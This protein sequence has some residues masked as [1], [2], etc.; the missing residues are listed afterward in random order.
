MLHEFAVKEFL[1]AASSTTSE[2]QGQGNSQSFTINLGG[3]ASLQIQTFRSLD[4]AINTFSPSQPQPPYLAAYH[5]ADLKSGKYLSQ[6]VDA[7]ISFINTIPSSLL[8]GSAAPT[9]RAIDLRYRYTPYMFTR[10]RPAF[11][12]TSKSERK[13]KAALTSSDSKSADELLKEARTP[14]KVMKRSQGGGVG[15]FEQGFLMNAA[16]ILLTGLTVSGLGVWKL[17]QFR[18]QRL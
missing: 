5:F 1:A 11:V 15:F 14:L 6:Y 13:L 2:K 10:S 16:F 9:A 18:S 3:N 17:W 7:E 8:I 12:E 4:D